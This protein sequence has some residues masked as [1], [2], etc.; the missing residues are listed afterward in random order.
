[1]MASPINDDVLA[2][3]QRILAS[4]P[5]YFPSNTAALTALYDPQKGTLV[6]HAFNIERTGAEVLDNHWALWLHSIPD[7]TAKA[8]HV[9]PTEEGG[10]LQYRGTG[11]FERNLAGK[12]EPTNRTFEYEAVLRAWIDRESGLIMRSEEFYTK[13]FGESDPVSM[14]TTAEA[15]PSKR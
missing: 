11:K 4:W 15:S 3:N 12:V 9:T 2:R 7:F 14:Y 13:T 5:T 6:D 10:W 1:M 8:I